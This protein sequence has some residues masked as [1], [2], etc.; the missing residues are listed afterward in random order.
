M[1]KTI[2]GVLSLVVSL[3]AEAQSISPSIDGIYCPTVPIT[4]T[5]TMPAS[6]FPYS[7]FTA[8][9]GPASEVPG[10]VGMMVTSQPT[11]TSNSTGVYFTF[12]GYF[13]DKSTVQG[14][15]F[16][17]T[18]ANGHVLGL[19][20]EYN[21]IESFSP[22]SSNIE[23]QAEQPQPNITSIQATACKSE[24]F[25]ISFPNVQYANSFV[26]PAIY[27]GTVTNYEYL[28]PSGWQLGGAT[29]DGSTWLPGSSNVIVTSDLTHGDGGSIQVRGAT[30]TAGLQPG[31][32]ASITISRPIKTSAY[33]I[34]GPMLLCNGV[35]ATYSVNGLQNG[36][37]SWSASPANIVTIAPSG[38][39]ATI[40]GGLPRDV[41]LNALVTDPCGNSFTLIYPIRSG[42][43]DVPPV[44]YINDAP[45]SSTTTVSVRPFNVYTLS[46]DPVPT[47]TSYIWSIGRNAVLTNGQGTNQVDVTITGAVGTSTSFSVQA[48]NDCG[49]GGGLN[50]HANVVGGGC[51]PC[52]MNIEASPNPVKNDLYISISGT[53]D[54]VKKAGSTETMRANLYNLFTTQMVRTW[55]LMP[56]QKQYHLSLQGVKK[57][58]YVLQLTRGSEKISKQILVE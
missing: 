23:K 10:S 13:V 49:R 34:S 39:Q 45:V 52:A 54:D 12:T 22:G 31:P 8:A 21:K 43:P 35:S 48:V 11:M 26:V 6:G 4:F 58:Q 24:S 16:T 1:R 56:G 57:G 53:T 33:S 17:T 5:V 51:D 37:V 30:C 41:I 15:H 40:T 29:S 20:F 28:L 47:A 42:N 50:I 36:S 19:F 55:S 46:V 25:N 14:L 18:D 7:N 3:F 44:M 9:G 38:N 27:F 32:A 2:A